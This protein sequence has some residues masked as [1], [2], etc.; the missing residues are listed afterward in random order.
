MYDFSFEEGR[1]NFKRYFGD[2][3]KEGLNYITLGSERK[4]IC[5]KC[6]KSKNSYEISFDGDALL[7]FNSTVLEENNQCLTCSRDTDIGHRHAK[8][9]FEFA[10]ELLLEKN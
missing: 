9:M 6:G 7:V 1:A 2:A 8:K 10:K 3:E 4:K 5:Q